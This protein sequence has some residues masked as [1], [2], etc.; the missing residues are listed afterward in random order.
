MI[1]IAANEDYSK[2]NSVIESNVLE[3]LHFCNFWTRK[4]YLDKKRIQAGSKP[5]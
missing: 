1:Y 3:F 2:I 5:K 4:A